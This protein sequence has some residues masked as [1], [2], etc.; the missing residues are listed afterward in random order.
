MNGMNSEKFDEQFTAKIGHG[1]DVKIPMPYAANGNG[2]I[3]NGGVKTLSNGGFVNYGYNTYLDTPFKTEFHFDDGHQQFIE[4][5]IDEYDDYGEQEKEVYFTPIDEVYVA[6]CCPDV[7]YKIMPCC[8]GDDDD[9]SPFWV[10]WNQ[11]RL[12]G[13]RYLIFPSLKLVSI[14]MKLQDT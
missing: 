10:V 3:S 1:M 9:E 7:I 11:Q 2:F 14:K 12:L 6:P 8:D 13:S 4:D 5:E